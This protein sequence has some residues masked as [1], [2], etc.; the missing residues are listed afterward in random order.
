MLKKFTDQK[1]TLEQLTALP[2]QQRAACMMLR[3]EA[4]P[5]EAARDNIKAANKGQKR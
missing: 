4:A 1:H 5:V 2:E 3:F